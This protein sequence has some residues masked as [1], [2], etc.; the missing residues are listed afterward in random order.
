VIEPTSLLLIIL[1]PA[2][3]AVLTGV[4]VGNLCQ[5]WLARRSE[6]PPASRSPGWHFSVRELLIAMSALCVFLAI[7]FGRIGAR[8][9]VEHEDQADFLSRFER[10]FTSGR[11]RL[12]NEPEIVGVQRTLI[13]ESG[14]RSFMAPGQNEYRVTAR[15]SKEGEEMWAVWAYTCNGE[16]DNLIYK[17]A[18]A[19][20]KLRSQLPLPPL[21]PRAYVNGTWQM[22][23]G[24]PK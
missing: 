24:V 15:I 19:E 20:A 23:D 21:P 16:H 10:S 13:P 8:E 4:V 17:Y 2:A 3:S 6:P 18:Y 12:T 14:Y 7:A 22:V 11:I 5:L 1:T 9:A